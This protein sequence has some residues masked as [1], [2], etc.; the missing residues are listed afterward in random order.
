MGNGELEHHLITVAG[1][2]GVFVHAYVMC[3]D[4]NNTKLS[5]LLSNIDDQMKERGV[6]VDIRF[7]AMATR[8][9]KS[10]DLV[11]KIVA[12]GNLDAKRAIE[13][14]TNFHLTIFTMQGNDPINARL[15][16]LH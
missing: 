4:F 1:Q 15:M 2:G 13:T 9:S 5:N 14:A 11:R 8:L 3:I 12:D 7:P 16:A 6:E 10:V